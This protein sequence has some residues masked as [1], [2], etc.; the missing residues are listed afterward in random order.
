MVKQ[1]GSKNISGV[2]GISPQKLKGSDSQM[3]LN[4]YE[5]ILTIFTIK[6]RNSLG[7]IV[8]EKLKDSDSQMILNK[9]ELIL[10]IFTIKFRNSLGKSSYE[11]HLLQIF[12]IKFRNSSGTASSTTTKTTTSIRHHEDHHHQLTP[13]MPPHPFPQ[14]DI[15]WQLSPGT[16]AAKC[17]SL[18]TDT[19]PERPCTTGP[20]GSNTEIHFIKQAKLKRISNK[21]ILLSKKKLPF[22]VFRLLSAKLDQVGVS[23]HQRYSKRERHTSGQRPLSTISDSADPHHI[24][25]VNRFEDGMEVSYCELLIPTRSWFNRGPPRETTR[26]QHS[27]QADTGDSTSE[28]CIHPSLARCYSYEPTARKLTEHYVPQSAQ[29]HLDKGPV[30]EVDEWRSNIPGRQS[31]SMQYVPNLL[32]DPELRAGKHRKLLR[33]S[34]YMSSVLEYT[35]P[36]ELKK[37]LN[38]KFREKFPHIN[39]TLSKLRSLKREMLKIACQ[40]SDIDILSVAHAYV[41]FERL[42]LKTIVNKL[43]RKLIAGACLILAAKMNDVKGDTLTNLIESE[44]SALVMLLGSSIGWGLMVMVVLKLFLYIT[45]WYACCHCECFPF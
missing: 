31:A 34:S 16:G 33:F 24:L 3:I 40:E 36:S 7:K 25:G 23:D 9:Y 12:T 21:V 37:E 45:L 44:K 14:N 22:I 11:K 10:T 5:R 8:Q 39:L 28:K 17:G 6:L 26:R 27:E 15:F 1:L 19:L 32:D 30:G 38:D 2:R 41:Y 42:I 35:K 43:N 20:F 18:T 4:K 13:N 29:M